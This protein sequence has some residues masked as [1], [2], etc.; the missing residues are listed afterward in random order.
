MKNEV[1]LQEV[2]KIIEAL[3]SGKWSDHSPDMLISAQGKLATYMGNIG[4]AVAS[5]E[6]EFRLKEI[7]H[8][9]YETE[10]Y[11]HWRKDGQTQMDA[12]MNAKLDAF[13]K[14]KDVYEAK[15]RWQSLRAILKA[16]ESLSVACSTTLKHSKVDTDNSN[17]QGN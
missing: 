15:E 10:Q 12:K 8:E 1:I 9:Q 6:Y 11:F 2:N 4:G 13:A 3:Q 16:M 7:H 14:E 5:A 17:F